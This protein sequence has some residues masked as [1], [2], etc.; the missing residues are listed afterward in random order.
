MAEATQQLRNTPRSAGVIPWLAWTHFLNDAV[1]NYLPGVLPFILSA[2]H[3]PEALAGTLITALGMGQGLQ[4][5]SG[6]IA[7]RIGG[8][9]LVLGG[10]ALSTISATLIGWAHPLWLLLTLLLFTGIG[11]TSF[12]PQALSLTRAQAGGRPGIGMAAFLVGGEIGRSLGPL[13]AGAVVHHWGLPWIWLLGIPLAITYPW[14]VKAIPAQKPR[15]AMGNSIHFKSHIKPATALVS[16]ALVRA[17]MVYE[18]TTLAPIMWHQQGGSLVT[19][20]ALVTVFI[21]VGIF[22]NM[23]GGSLDDRV[24]KV[25]VLLGTSVLSVITLLAFMTLHGAWEWPILA[26]MGIGAFGS[27]TTTTL[28][29]QDVFPENPALGSGIGLGLSNA[30][31]AIMAFPLTYIA[32][33]AGY[34]V[35]IL[36][37]VALTVITAPA[38][39]WMPKHRPLIQ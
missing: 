25:R 38:V 12:H 39:F 23:L 22:G 21:G 15:R 6:W 17:G 32:A 28:V 2:R 8:R 26:L 37:L 9:S 36:I 27:A 3:I 33:R 31:G 4:P 19:G 29:G 14:I 16:Y 7:D 20:A 34:S 10:V 13:A 11:N 18:I 24:G 1:V 5:L 30:L 35:T